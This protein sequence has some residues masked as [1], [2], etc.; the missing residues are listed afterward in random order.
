MRVRTPEAWQ[1]PAPEWVPLAPGVRWKLKTPDGGVRAVVAADVAAIM[2]KVYQG[3][4][5]LE[6]LG[7]EDTGAMGE[8]FNLDRLSGYASCLTACL[9][10]RHCLEEWEGIVDPTS[11]EPLDHQDPDNI[12]AALLHGAPPVGQPLLA[13]FLAWIEKPRRPM[14]AEAIRLRD[15]A[16]DHWAGGAERCRACAD[17][18]DPCQKGASVEGEMCPRLKNTPQTPEGVTAWGIASTTS[19]LW[20]RG[21]MDGTVT[22]LD[23]RAALLAF[24]AETSGI[25]Q[26]VDHGA[27][28]AAFR[29]IEQGR[30]QA[31]ADKAEAESKAG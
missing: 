13:P 27:A 19:G 6:A 29:A 21:G 18:G 11:G 12:R 31:Q 20:Q 9:F 7:I 26:T 28:F 17:E 2:A 4:D 22:G 16:A 25:G 15:L 10:A 8:V 14:I 1:I 23:Y 5:G 24:E 3:R 30:M